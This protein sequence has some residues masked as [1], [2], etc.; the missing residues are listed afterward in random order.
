MKILIVED[1]LHDLELI[2]NRLKKCSF[3]WSYEHCD[4][5]KEF[6]ELLKKEQFDFIIC[7]YNLPSFN[8][9][10]ALK[11]ARANIEDIPFFIVSGFIGEDQ[12]VELIVENG[13]TDYISKNNLSR[14]SHSI[15]REL[16]NLKAR[17][18]LKKN[19]L[20]HERSLMLLKAINDITT[21]L[22]NT[23]SLSEI[24]NTITE[25]IMTHFDFEDC[26]IYSFDDQTNLLKQIAAIGPKKNPD[27]S[28]NNAITLKL[29]EGI[30][31]SVA[32][33]LQPEIVNDLSNDSRYVVDI[34]S[35]NSEITVPILLNDELIG[36]ID[37]E[38]EEKG[39]YTQQHLQD[40]QTVA[41]VIATKFKAGLE[42][43]K[44]QKAALK[45]K[46]SEMQLRQISENIE[47]AVFRYTINPEGEGKFLFVSTKTEEIFEVTASDALEDDSLIWNLI[48]E[49]DKDWVS[50]VYCEAIEAEANFN[51][52]FRIITPSGKLKW[53]ETAGSI[54]K[55]ENGSVISDTLNK[56]ITDRVLA[57]KKIEENESLL[58]SLTNNIPGVIIRH[59]ITEGIE[60]PSIEFI[61]E[62]CLEI[63]E[64][65]RDEILKDN[66]KLKE[67][68]YPEDLEAM[69]PTIE[70]SAREMADWNFT[71][72][73]KTK[74]GKVKYLQ[75]NGTPQRIH[76][77]NKMIWDTV[78]LDITNQK[79]TE[80]QLTETNNSLKKAH[81]VGE[82][83][84]WSLDLKTNKI[85][86][87]EQLY[88]IYDRDNEQG[89]P[90]FEGFLDYHDLTD[91]NMENLIK[92]I[93]SGQ[94]YDV[95]LKL[96][97]KQGVSKYI[98]AIGSPEKNNTGEVI[99]YTGLAQD[100]TRR[101]ELQKKV[102]N[103]QFTLDTAIKGANLGVWDANI[104]DQTSIMNDRWYEMLGY[105]PQEIDDPYGFFF[106][107]IHPED[108]DLILN[109]IGLIEAGEKDNF[110][111][112]I[113][114][115][116]KCG[117][118]RT[119]L[120]KGTALEYDDEGRLIRMIGTHLDITEQEE[121]RIKIENSLQEKTLLLSEIHHRV[122]NNL[123]IVTGLLSLQHLGSDDEKLKT[124]LSETAQ[125]IKSIAQV[126]ELLYNTDSFTNIPFDKYLHT[127][128]SSISQTLDSKNGVINLDIDKNLEIN[129]NQAIPLGLLLN[130]LITNSFKYAFDSTSKNNLI[131][132]S[133]IFKDDTYYA[134]YYDSG[135][136]FDKAKLNNLS[137]L[138]SL[139]IDTL[140]QQLEADFSI[141]TE[142]GYH[143]EFSFKEIL[144]GS[145]SNF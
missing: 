135:A 1:N 81:K 21:S 45:L 16:E 77:E 134:K 115:K 20:E 123:A 125:R 63:Y 28:I 132:F 114:V 117:E 49:K 129:I 92:S 52:E 39:F 69:A 38:H 109:E 67:I 106:T 82:L 56:D 139:L 43:E 17:R 103:S 54:T 79:E 80:I 113:R 33:T 141:E 121:L 42:L 78:I 10:Q 36:I 122:K 55:L 88:D 34:E 108:S 104:R 124:V 4:N 23:D 145:H 25:K 140:L 31:G 136:G 110:E 65:S 102:Q 51:L 107:R 35:N 99:R 62:G 85:D 60:N 91:S 64:I 11:I 75:G 14:L 101:L 89:P 74:S 131:H 58:R 118:Y 142:S 128:T 57:S 13:A 87:S 22:L 29:G 111:I 126:H 94:P 12:A 72:R 97:T 98:R 90:D 8:C 119:I 66:S 50:R 48:H 71:Y 37:S 70:K 143:I 130:E 41:G 68:I 95:D 7:D 9:I 120:D 61:S 26:V 53:I 32:K 93:Q 116:C 5:E 137:S 138:G 47:T 46:Q 127:L 100:I 76:S 24:S 144:S 27:S 6:K 112:I 86:W 15:A 19:R 96:I 30:V 18:E 133:L 59:S 83:G 44:S 40:L 73:I 2:L 84:N 3:A 105:D